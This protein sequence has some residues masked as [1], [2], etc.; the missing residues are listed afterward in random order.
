MRY[1]RDAEPGHFQPMNSN[2]GLVDP[3]ET[4]VRD[5]KVKRELLAERAQSD[6]LEWMRENEIEVAVE[7]SRVG[8]AE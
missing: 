8:A 7:G 1:L 4:P 2:W 5:K 6:F 3:L